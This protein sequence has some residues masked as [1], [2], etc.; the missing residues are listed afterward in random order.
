M[1]LRGIFNKSFFRQGLE[2]QGS[3]TLFI[4]LLEKTRRVKFLESLNYTVYSKGNVWLVMAE[5]RSLS[6][7]YFPIDSQVYVF[8]P[9]VD[10]INI[11][12][13]Y[14]IDLSMKQEVRS[15]GSWKEN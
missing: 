4:T 1:I 9:L 15:Y 7:I 10:G 6:N 11:S 5:D 3:Q 2:K 8:I 13:I 14:N 12:E